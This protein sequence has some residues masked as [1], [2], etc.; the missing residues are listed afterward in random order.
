MTGVAP[1]YNI[2]QSIRFSSADSAYMSRTVGSGGNTK[3]WTVSCWFKIGKLTSTRGASSFLW[4][5]HQSDG[6]RLQLSFDSGTLGN[7]GDYLSIY[8][9]ASASTIF[10]TNRVFRDPSAWYH[11]IIVADTSNAISTERF[12]VYLNGE[13]E[14]SFST[15]N[16]P[17]LNADLGWNQNGSTYYLGDYFASHNGTYSFDGYIA[18]FVHIDGTA[19]DPSSFGLTNESGIWIP[20]DVS[21]L[22]FGT[23]GFHIDG[24]DSADLGDDESGQG[25]DFSTSGLGTHDQMVGESPTNNFAVLNPLDERGSGTLSDGN[26]Q[27]AFGATNDNVTATQGLNTGKLYWEVYIVDKDDPYVGVQD[28]GVASTGYTEDAVALWVDGG[29][30]YEDGSDTGDRSTTY[31]NGDIVGV[32]FDVDN[33]KIWWSKNGQ[34]YSADDSS[35]ATINISEVEAG[36]QAQVITRSPD[37]FMPFV[38]N[39]NTGTVIMNFGQEGTFAGNVTAGGN[40]DGNGVGNFK[41]SVPSGYLALCTKNLGS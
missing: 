27:M 22:T 13:R 10:R 39:Y 25:N 5:C 23:K 14:T 34:W 7:A 26:L 11:L 37:F 8:D 24:R 30:I 41:Y 36:N 28:S 32:A 2:S 16:Y 20:K 6:N 1:P 38:G 19:L 33:K 31:A 3:T 15:I 29:Y 21:D 9:G 12:R 35:T 18:E 17:A 4:V 40:S